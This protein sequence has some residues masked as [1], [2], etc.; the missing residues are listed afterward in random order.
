MRNRIM[1]AFRHPVDLLENQVV[2]IAGERELRSQAEND[3]RDPRSSV[4]HGG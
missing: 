4:C 1:A 3:Y 2:A